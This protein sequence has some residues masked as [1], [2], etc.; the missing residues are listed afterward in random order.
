MVV[1]VGAVAALEVDQAIVIFRPSKLRLLAGLERR[2]IVEARKLEHHYPHALK[3][4]YKG[5]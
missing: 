4:K 2:N 5:S 1:V 3:V